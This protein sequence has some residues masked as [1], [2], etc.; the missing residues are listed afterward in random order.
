VDVRVP[1]YENV[2]IE[3]IHRQQRR[4]TVVENGAP[5]L[6]RIDTV[7]AATRDAALMLMHSNGI[8]C[9][10]VGTRTILM[11]THKPIA[12]VQALL[13]QFDRQVAG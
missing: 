13:D 9:A 2:V 1:S 7:F 3:I 10:A 8:A 11:A 5:D 12:E 4:V 6:Y